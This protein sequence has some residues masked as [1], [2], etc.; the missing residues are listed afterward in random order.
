MKGGQ[1]MSL[2][3]RRILAAPAGAAA[4][5]GSADLRYDT[6]AVLSICTR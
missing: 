3:R 5:L 1:D 6:T 4:A 2:T